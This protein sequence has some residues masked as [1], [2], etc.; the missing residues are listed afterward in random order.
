MLIYQET[1]VQEL[2]EP[3]A[4]TAGIRLLVKREDLN[5]PYVSGNKW[6][7]LKHNLSEI[8]A[9][10]K[11][12]IL[13]FG[14]A[15]SNHIYATAAAAAECNIKCIGFIRGEERLPLNPTLAAAVNFGMTLQYISR[16]EY[17]KK[18]D[19][20]FLSELK[21]KWGDPYLLPE[22]GT[23]ELG[24]LGAKEFGI[25]LQSTS[26]DYLCVAVGTGGTI[27]GLIQATPEGAEII[28]F[29]AIKGEGAL[30]SDI[31]KLSGEHTGSARWRLEKAYH[32]G[33]YAKTTPELMAFMGQFERTHGFPLDPVYTGKMMY[34]VFDLL[35]QGYF[36][37]GSTVL[38]IHTGGLRE[39]GRAHV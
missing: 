25:G 4:R 39:I 9:Q 31:A 20:A 36:P 12:T 17:R 35:K 24:V 30:A 22:G 5:H 19:E 10:N 28:G 38:A 37:R 13:T 14:G 6:W 2:D 15:Y 8:S 18:K 32:H 34:G 23:N 26:F 33:G 16:E 11:D 1:P 27:A 29:P 21:E 3:I 7:K